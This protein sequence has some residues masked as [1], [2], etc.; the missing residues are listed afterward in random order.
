MSQEGS[1]VLKNAAPAK[2]ALSAMTQSGP[3]APLLQFII[4]DNFTRV[5]GHFAD[6]RSS[7]ISGILCTHH[8]S[9][10]APWL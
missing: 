4:S 5:V 3:N 1:N 6:M 8:E 2:P 9:P 10:P 7:S